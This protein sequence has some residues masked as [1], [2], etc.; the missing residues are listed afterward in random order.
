MRKDQEKQENEPRWSNAIGVIGENES[1]S[2]HPPPKAEPAHK[3]LLQNIAG[4][5]ILLVEDNPVNQ[6]VAESILK[7]AHLLVETVWNGKEAVDLL[8]NNPKHE[9]PAYSA[10]LMDVEMPVLD[11][12]MATELIRKEAYLRDIPI[13]AMTA[14]AFKRDK[15]RCIKAG[16]NDYIAKPIDE[17]E[18]LTVLTKWIN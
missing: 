18:L 1:L 10:V 7:Q 13:I 2:P 16:M 12:Y 17:R 8:R 4:S 6:L 11:G 14:H 15:D 9:A 5:K 3:Q